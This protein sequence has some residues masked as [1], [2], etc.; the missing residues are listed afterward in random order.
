MFDKISLFLY[1][2][3]V[4]NG[5][6]NIIS[7]FDNATES[8]DTKTGEYKVNGN[9]GTMKLFLSN[10]SG[11]SIRGSLPKYL[12]GNNVYPLNRKTTGEALEKL[13]DSLHIDVKQAKVTS[14]EF[15]NVFLMKYNVGQY[16]DRLG[17]LPRYERVKVTNT[18]LRYETDGK[19]KSKVF[20]FYD[21]AK[22]IQDKGGIIPQGFEKQNL[23]KYELRLKGN[24]ATQLKMQEV[25]AHTL[26]EYECNKKLVEMYKHYFFNIKG[27]QQ[28]SIDFGQMK[29]KTVKEIED[30]VFAQLL[31]ERG[32]DGINTILKEC[33]SG[34]VFKHKSEYTRL[35]N[36]LFNKLVSG[37]KDEKGDDLLNELKD[38]IFNTGQ[39]L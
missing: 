33:K 8:T 13:S 34:D 14:I 7:Y 29:G 39:N 16:L 28:K 1:A 11:L 32:A 3:E 6:N 30:L 37:E 17:N 24:I 10:F 15:G 12:Y 5:N 27:I 26:I 35:K 21:K 18:T 9:I 23:L 38:A 22:E 2:D 25:T 4:K 20:C 19:R 36:S 31:S